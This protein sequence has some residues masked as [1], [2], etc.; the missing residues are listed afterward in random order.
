[1][2]KQKSKTS[3]TTYPI[4]LA[5]GVGTRLWPISRE[6]FPKQLASLVGFDSLIQST[7]KRLLPLLDTQ[8]VRVVCGKEYYYEIKRHLKDIGISSEG[9]IITE[10]CGRNTAPAVLLAVLNI[11]K[12]EKDAILLI[13]PADH[14]IS[15]VAA[16]QEKLKTAIKLA[17]MDYIVTFGLKPHYPETGYGYIEGT[18]NVDG[19][20]LHI[21][22]FIEKPDKETA[23]QYLEAGN[24]FWNSGIFAFKASVILKEYKVFQPD[25]LKDMQKILTAGDSIPRESYEH[26]SDISIDYAIME[27]TQ[28]GLV[29]PSDFGWSDIG[30]WKSLYDFLPKDENDNVVEGDVITRETKNSFI[31][32]YGRL[33]VTNGLKNIVVVETPDTVFVSDLNKS[34]DVKY[35]V[36]ELKALGR[37]EYQAHTTVYRPWGYYTNL[38]EKDNTKLKR[39]VLYPKAKLSLQMHYHRAEHW[40]VVH[41]TAKIINGDQ[42]LLLKENESTYIPKA[43]LHRLENP[44]KIPL[45]IIEVQMGNY[46]EEDDIVRYDDDFGRADSKA[47]D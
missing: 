36:N 4:L 33:I 13:L 25:L 16:F 10:P 17:E 1:M 7:I 42:T 12:V 2:P 39:I 47:P 30:S 32:G 11:L 44:G 21:K 19:D 22:R 45:H 3:L 26:L 20:A 14:V 9:K 35:I 37:K 5:G 34:Q 28:K 15:D 43:T 31:K 29:L 38:E 8:S 27:K 24:Y 6:L 40:V 18:Q 46:V 23:E 41:G